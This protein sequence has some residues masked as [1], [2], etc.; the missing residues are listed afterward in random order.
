MSYSNK[1]NVDGNA[2]NSAIGLAKNLS[3][4]KFY[5][6]YTEKVKFL[7]TDFYNSPPEFYITS[8]EQEGKDMHEYIEKCKMN[9]IF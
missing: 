5:A 6:N 3:Q 8:G 4:T 2:L 9:L 7:C 1:N